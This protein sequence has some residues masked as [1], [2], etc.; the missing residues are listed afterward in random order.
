[1]GGETPRRPPDLREAGASPASWPEVWTRGL[2]LHP[3][4]RINGFVGRGEGDTKPRVS[5]G[6]LLA[7]SPSGLTASASGALAFGP[8]SPFPPCVTA[9][10]GHLRLRVRGRRVF[11]FTWKCYS[12]SSTLQGLEKRGFAER[13]PKAP[14]ERPGPQRRS[15]GHGGQRHGGGAAAVDGEAV[16]GKRLLRKKAFGIHMS[17]NKTVRTQARYVPETSNRGLSRLL[18]IENKTFVSSAHRTFKY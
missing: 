7:A 5:P 10:H 3:R 13:F 6:G 4:P 2:W 15:G 1:M 9:C 16:G 17:G 18:R 12:E 11:Y 8:L 14:E